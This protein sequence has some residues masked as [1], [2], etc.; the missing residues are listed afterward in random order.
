MTNL[1]MTGY[2]RM[3]PDLDLSQKEFTLGPMPCGRCG[4]THAISFH[5]LPTPEAGIA[6]ITQGQFRMVVTHTGRCAVSGETVYVGMAYP[7]DTIQEQEEKTDD[8]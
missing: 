7:N 5:R 2:D 1:P 6:T 3:V 8:D 4:T